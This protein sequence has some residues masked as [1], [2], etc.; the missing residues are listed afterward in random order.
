MLNPEEPVAAKTI[1]N[2]DEES[3]P[4]E[5][6]SQSR[7]DTKMHDVPLSSA[8]LV[9]SPNK[10]SDIEAKAERQRQQSMESNHFRTTSS[11]LP[12]ES[13]P[14]TDAPCL[15]CRHQEKASFCGR[16]FLVVCAAVALAGLIWQHLSSREPNRVGRKFKFI[17][18]GSDDDANFTRI[19][20]KACCNGLETNCRLAVDEI[21]WATAHNAMSSVDDGF[22]AANNREQLEVRKCQC[23]D[24]VLFHM[25]CYSLRSSPFDTATG[26][27]WTIYLLRARSMQATGHSCSILASAAI[28]P[29]EW[30][31]ATRPAQWATGT[32]RRY[33][34]VSRHSCPSVHR[35]L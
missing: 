30:C 28:S 12:S 3:Q 9:E 6:L 14:N 27:F 5:V 32:R 2:E 18:C 7:V 19:K 17:Q 25:V 22:V 21:M 8:Q 10:P 35:R 20:G 34:R 16:S 24:W 29:I 31:S 13:D 15:K 26:H 1:Q 33:S 4:C 11:Y 23:H